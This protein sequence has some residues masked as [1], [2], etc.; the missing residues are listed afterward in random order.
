VG[1]LTRG[2]VSVSAADASS[3]FIRFF[4]AVFSTATTEVIVSGRIIVT[5]TA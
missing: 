4:G 2:F 3:F 5:D 1:D